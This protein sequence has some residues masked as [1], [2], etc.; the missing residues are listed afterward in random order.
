[1]GCGASNARSPAEAR[2]EPEGEPKQEDALTSGGEGSGVAERS[3][4]AARTLALPVLSAAPPP[5][6]TSTINWVFRSED[7]GCQEIHIIGLGQARQAAARRPSEPML[8]LLQSRSHRSRKRVVAGRRG[9]IMDARADSFRQPVRCAQL[10]LRARRNNAVLPP[11]PPPPPA[12]DLPP[13]AAT[14]GAPAA[15]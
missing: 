3:R 15:E 9:S 14:P 2:P 6:S 8:E 5:V 11:P 10:L 4:A 1:M 12:S 7:R 13:A